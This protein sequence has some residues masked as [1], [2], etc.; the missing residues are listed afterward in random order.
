MSD[1]DTTLEDVAAAIDGAFWM[2]AA[3]VTPGL[4]ERRSVLGATDEEAAQTWPGDDVVPTPRWWWHHTID[5]DAPASEVWPWVVQMGADRGGF[6]SYEGLENLA[7]CRIHNADRI[8]PEWQ[9]L[10]VGDGLRLHP[11]MP[12][13]PIRWVEPGQ[14]FVAGIRF[15]RGSDRPIPVGVPLPDEHS[16][17]SWLFHITALSPTRSRFLS[18][19]RVSYGD[20]VASRLSMGPTFVEPIGT[21]MDRQMLAGLRE[22]GEAERKNRVEKGRGT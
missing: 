9:H 1:R 3:F 17:V 14:G 15:E 12:A 22:R 8:H 10:A 2:I 6:Y 16:A 13:M 11:E 4:R 18:R 7:G 20:D 21:V 19:Y 5:I